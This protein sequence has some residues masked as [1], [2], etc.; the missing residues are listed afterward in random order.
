[1]SHPPVQKLHLPKDL[2]GVEPGK[3]APALLKPIP[4]GGKLH[5]LAANAWNAMHA[6]AMADGIK[7]LAPTSAGDTYRSYDLQKTG[8]LSRYVLEDTGTGKTR[9]F[10]GKTWYLKKG[11][12][13]MATPGSSRHNLG[14][15]VD[16]ANANGKKFEWLCANAP[17]FGWSLEV[18]PEEPWHWFYFC[19]DVIPPAVS[20][21][22]GN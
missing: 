22:L 1:M 19:G 9:K 7:E 21:F 15:A 3:L 6:Q 13:P 16:I 14:L 12:A 11:M 2:V 4:Q 17:K 8:F 20:A 5:H 18:M 10:E